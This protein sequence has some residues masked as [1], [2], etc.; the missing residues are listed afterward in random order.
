M[1]QVNNFF[2]NNSRSQYFFFVIWNK[3]EIQ[4][5]RYA[6]KPTILEIFAIP[7]VITY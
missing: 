3:D 2:V 5:I 1:T 7:K 6:P 4:K